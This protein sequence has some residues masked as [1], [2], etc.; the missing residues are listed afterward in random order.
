MSRAVTKGLPARPLT[1]AEMGTYEG[2]NTEVLL[3]P[4][5]AWTGDGEDD[6]TIVIA[7]VCTLPDRM[8]LLGFDPA[9]ETWNAVI[10]Q[11]DFT[12]IA[13]VPGNLNLLEQWLFERYPLDELV[14]INTEP[15]DFLSKT[16]GLGA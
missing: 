12:D 10:H 11:T 8:S 13:A 1:F 4:F 16:S 7:V 3:T 5:W 6:D 14:A 9:T 15:L 2:E